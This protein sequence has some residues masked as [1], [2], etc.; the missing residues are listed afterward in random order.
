MGSDKVLIAIDRED[1]DEWFRAK[2]GSIHEGPMIKAT[3]A[4][5][6]RDRDELIEV[7]AREIHPSVFRDGLTWC[8]SG[9]P[10]SGRLLARGDARRVLAAIERADQE[11]GDDG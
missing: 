4:A 8:D 1:A 10:E 3:R 5:L 9:M 11:E 2:P 6:D 7:I